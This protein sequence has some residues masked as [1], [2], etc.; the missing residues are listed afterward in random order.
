LLSTAGA[1]TTVRIENGSAAKLYSIISSSALVGP[2]I[3]IVRR[4][5]KQMD[6]P[7]RI[8]N[9]FSV[10]ELSHACALK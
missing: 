10:Q 7:K 9:A 5:G 8:T 6:N 4:S 1:T 3:R 2:L